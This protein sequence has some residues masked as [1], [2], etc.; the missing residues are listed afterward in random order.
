MKNK[1]VMFIAS[2]QD[3][4]GSDWFIFMAPENCDRLKEFKFAY[5]KEQ[6]KGTFKHITEQGIYDISTAYDYRDKKGGSYSIN[7]IKD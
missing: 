3:L 2:Y 5:E 6:G 1:K 7:L 4:E